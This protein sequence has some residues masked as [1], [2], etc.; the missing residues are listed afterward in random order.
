MF[1]RKARQNPLRTAVACQFI[2]EFRIMVMVSGWQR[3]A[4]FL[5]GYLP[6]P[7][8]DD[9]VFA[10]MLAMFFMSITLAVLDFGPLLAPWAQGALWVTVVPIGIWAALA[11]PD[12]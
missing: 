12:L 8:C 6:C 5:F 7:I 4:L 11:F 2:S 3:M 10:E 1:G 9:R